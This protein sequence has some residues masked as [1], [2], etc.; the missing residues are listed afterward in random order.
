MKKRSKQLLALL[1]SVVLGVSITGCGSKDAQ[2]EAPAA[3]PESG[4]AVQESAAGSSV[5]A[6]DQ[7]DVVIKWVLYW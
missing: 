5:A 6:D 2:T 7:D 1:M 4:T 3:Q